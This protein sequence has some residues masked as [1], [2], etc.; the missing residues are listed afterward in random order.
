[1]FDNRIKVLNRFLGWVKSDDYYIH[2]VNSFDRT[3][4][5][6]K[7]EIIVVGRKG[8]C[9]WAYLNCPCGC[10]EI[11]NLSL[12]KSH[13][14]HWTIKIDSLARPTLYPSIWKNDGCKSH[15]WIKNGK[16]SWCEDWEDFSII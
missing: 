5:P 16:I 2:K 1:M 11:L 3:F 12:M 15:F 6:A 14:P 4:I 9:K 7:N 10:N 13:D 8:Y